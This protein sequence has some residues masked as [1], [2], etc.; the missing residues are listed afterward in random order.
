M[1][2]NG[3]APKHKAAPSG[4]ARV[5]RQVSSWTS[6]GILTV[7]ILVAGLVFGREV[8]TWW[9]ADMTAAPQLARGVAVGEGLGNPA[10]P[11]WLQFGDQSWSFTL[12]VVGGS[13]K[14]AAA[15]L[16]ANCRKTTQAAVVPDDPPGSAELDFLRTIAGGK[17]VEEEAG[18]WQLYELE[19]AYPMAAG[20]L[21]TDSA[22]R[23]SRVESRELGITPPQFARRVVTWG[24]AVPR[25]PNTWGVYAFHT[26]PPPGTPEQHL[27]EVALPP[28]AQRILAIGAAGG[29]G[30]LSFRGPP[31]VETW[32]Q[33]FDSW[34]GSRGWNA[35]GG[36]RQY[37]LNWH[38]HCEKDRAGSGWSMDIHFGPDG[39]GGQTGL[40]I[41][42]P[43]A[44][45][46]QRK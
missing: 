1:K 4:F 10:E 44:G 45:L 5:A 16:R 11:H 19:G 35:A 38:L 27:S 2:H 33:F 20:V 43:T 6:K 31:E 18:R 3:Q 32:K 36:W 46:N 30:M 39:R 9:G 8:L 34:L 37:G 14:E 12:Q 23:E 21:S 15:T 41:V 26:A 40:V 24:L 29:G 42:A 28:G 17:P 25:G 7:V 13:A 22:S